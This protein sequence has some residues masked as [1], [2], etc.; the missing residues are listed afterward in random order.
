MSKLRE[1]MRDA[2]VVR[3][4]ALRTQ[5]SYIEALAKLSRHYRCGLERLEAGQVEAWLL[6]LLKD[7]KLSYST[8]NQAASACR[9]LYGQVLRRS[10]GICRS[11]G[12]SE[13]HHRQAQCGDRAGARRS[14]Y[15][16]DVREMGHRTDSW[17]AR[18]VRRLYCA[19]VGAL[20]GICREVQSKPG[21]GPMSVPR[22][23]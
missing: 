1:Q 10:E 11:C 5:Q 15:E 19:R 3:G 12:P 7:R 21:L 22:G 16:G 6:H 23:I 20:E 4:Y 13:D 14:G 9:F 18:G 8:V 2:M 17:H